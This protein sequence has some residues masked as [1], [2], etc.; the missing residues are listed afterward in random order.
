M[1]WPRVGSIRL[2]YPRSSGSSARSPAPALTCSPANRPAAQVGQTALR[3]RENGASPSLRFEDWK[4][5]KK[6]MALIAKLLVAVGSEHHGGSAGGF[7]VMA[8][9]VTAV[10]AVRRIERPQAGNGGQNLCICRLLQRAAPTLD[11]C[12]RRPGVDGR[13]KPGHD[14]RGSERNRKW[15]DQ[16]LTYKRQKDRHLP[17]PL[18][19]PQR[20]S[21]RNPVDIT[22][23]LRYLAG[24]ANGRRLGN[25][26]ASH[27]NRS[28][29][30]RF[31]ALPAS[32]AQ[33]SPEQG[34]VP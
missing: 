15:T 5:P 3:L 4:N 31:L 1:S 2:S 7:S 32:V 34:R 8:V 26:A 19:R 33:G 22:N 6:R 12:L 11:S 10:H 14:D 30:T 17:K 25:G 23:I 16:Q 28:K 13:D 20:P 29:P 9:L 18:T 27:W 24:A 21:R